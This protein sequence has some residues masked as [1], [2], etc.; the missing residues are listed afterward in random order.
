MGGHNSFISQNFSLL[1]PSFRRYFLEGETL[2]RIFDCA[3]STSRSLSVKIDCI[4]QAS[5]P[6]VLFSKRYSY[7]ELII[8]IGIG[9]TII[10]IGSKGENERFFYY[11][12]EV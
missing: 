11:G 8:H 6:I 5:T 12:L 7:P 4:L 3:R 10:R 2:C 9:P 1:S